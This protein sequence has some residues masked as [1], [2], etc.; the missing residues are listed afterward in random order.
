MEFNHSGMELFS[1]DPE[2][3][4]L[5][6]V[7]TKRMNVSWYVYTHESRLILLASGMQCKSFTGFQ[8]YMLC[9][10]VAKTSLNPILSLL[11]LEYSIKNSFP[12][13]SFV[14]FP[15]SMVQIWMYA[16][17]FSILSA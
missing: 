16:S 5:H 2:S 10:S 12:M 3:K 8:V 6:L 11:C 7:E 17:I 9:S 4:S 15:F 13:P 14:L 1:Y